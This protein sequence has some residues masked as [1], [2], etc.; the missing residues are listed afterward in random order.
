MQDSVG[1]QS[2]GLMPE[3]KQFV[4]K[5]ARGMEARLLNWGA[6]LTHLLVP[7]RHGNLQDV[8]L[9][10]DDP[11]QYQG[12]HPSFGSSVGRFANRIAHGRFVIDGEVVEVSKNE[13]LHMLHGGHRGFAQRLWSATP[14]SLPEGEAV[15]FD[16]LSAD[17][18]EGFPGNLEVRV[19]YV[20]T[21]EGALAIRYEARTDRPTMV[22]LTNH[23]YF[24]LHGR[25]SILD[26]WLEL[27]AGHF[28]PGG[29]D[30]IPFGHTAPVYGPFDFTHAKPIGQDIHHPDL[31]N[32]RGYDHN[33]VVDGPKGSLR[34]AARTWTEETGILMETWTTEPCIQLY[35]GNWLNEQGE[36]RG[37][38]VES[39]HAFCLETQHAPNSPNEPAF[40]SPLLR[41]GEV[42]RSETQYRFGLIS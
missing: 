41:P 35:T 17:G 31:D 19:T 20:L 28:T 25:G 15:Q 10:F 6:T 16:Y 7:D 39:R 32:R 8:V 9:G 13:G 21:K 22:N 11:A 40:D 4:L 18:E 14:L 23:A 33:F 30:G 34:P 27:K 29:A 2:T 5:N 1:E 38:I 12:P 36:K 42:F 24:N 37:G 26:H 3:L